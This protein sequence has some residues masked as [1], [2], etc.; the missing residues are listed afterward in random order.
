MLR[1]SQYSTSAFNCESWVTPLTAIY[2]FV[3]YH[4]S[5][6]SHSSIETKLPK[7]FCLLLP[8]CSKWLSS[9]LHSECNFAYCQVQFPWEKSGYAKQNIPNECRV[10]CEAW[11]AILHC[12]EN[13]T[14]Y[15][16]RPLGKTASKWRKWWC[17]YC[18]YFFHN[19]ELL[20]LLTDRNGC[21]CEIFFPRP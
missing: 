21:P 11:N 9:Q 5:S 4:Q 10:N 17:C 3:C 19:G 2:L 20:L 6:K 16:F 15:S 7:R 18:R 12:Q 14:C 1:E 13:V 8:L